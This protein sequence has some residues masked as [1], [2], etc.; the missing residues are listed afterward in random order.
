MNRAAISYWIP[1]YSG[2]TNETEHI[3]VKYA[4][5]NIEQFRLKGRLLD[6]ITVIPA[7]D[8]VRGD[9]PGIQ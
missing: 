6:I 2:T 7:P 9:G 8:R 3:S 4:F 1:A 5:Q